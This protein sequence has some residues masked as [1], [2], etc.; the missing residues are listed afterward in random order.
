MFELS[1]LKKRKVMANILCIV[2]FIATIACLYRGGC[3]P[4][5]NYPYASVFMLFFLALSII[6]FFIGICISALQ[7]DI[8]EISNRK[9]VSQNNL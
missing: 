7:K 5:F 6:F 2:C 1:R 4:L 8:T 3:D 9:S